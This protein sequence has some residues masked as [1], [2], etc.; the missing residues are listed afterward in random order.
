MSYVKSA[1]QS[2]NQAVVSIGGSSSSGSFTV[3]GE[4][5]EFSQSGTMNKTDDTT[6][7]NSIAEEFLPTILTPGSFSGTMNRVSGDTGQVA[8]KAA[9][10]GI[11][12]GVPTTPTLNYWKVQLAKNPNATPPQ[13]VSGDSL[14]FLGMV[15]EFTN[16]GTVKTD[17]KVSTSFKIKVSGAIYETLGS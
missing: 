15:E 16:F 12:G 17:K 7:L 6:N 5:S 13:T 8:V 14:V 4:I 1:A 10:G 11:V 9:F 2:G 3:V